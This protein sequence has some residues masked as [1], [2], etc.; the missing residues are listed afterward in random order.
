MLLAGLFGQAQQEAHAAFHLMRIH[1]VM[2][3][4]NAVNTIQYVELRMC[5]GGQN[6]VTGHTIRFYDDTNPTPVLK[7]TFT[8]PGDVSNPGFATGE[9]ILIATAEYNANHMGPGAG[10]SGGNADFIFSDGT[11]PNW[12]QNTVG[13]NGGDPLHPVQF[14]GG[15]VV[16]EE[17]SFS[18][19]CA[20]N[21]APLDSVAYGGAVPNYGTAAVALPSPSDN[22]ALRESNLSGPTNNSTDY[23]L[24]ATAAVPETVASGSLSTDLD[25]PRNNS[26]QVSQLTLDA[27]GDAVN[28]PTD[29][30][31]GTASGATVDSVG[32]SAAQVD[33]DA[34]GVCDVGAESDGPQN[35]TGFPTPGDLCPGTAPAAAV[36][37]VGC[38]DAQ[39]DPDNDGFCSPGAPDPPAGPSN[40][41]VIPAPDNCPTVSNPL[42]EDTDMDGIGDACETSDGDFDEV[43]DGPDNC[44]TAANA[45]QGNQDG[46]GLGDACDPDSDADGTAN[47]TDNDDDND[48]V[49]DTAEG[50]CRDDV[51]SADAN[52]F[53]ND[54]CPAVGLAESGAQCS[55]MM[56]ESDSDGDGFVNDG[57]PGATEVVGCGGD[58]LSPARRPERIDGAFLATDDDADGSMNEVLPAGSSGLDCDGDGWPGD[59]ENLLYGNAP[60]T[61]SNQ[62]PCGN[63]GWPT[64]L[65][66]NNAL[67]IAD[68][69]S[70]LN[71]PRSGLNPPV[72]AHSAFNKFSHPLDDWGAGGPGGGMSPDGTIDPEMARWNLQMPPHAATTAINIGDLNSLITGAAGSPARPP[73]FNGQQ[74]FFTD[75]GMCPWPA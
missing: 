13:A 40:C 75:G 50:E 69:G 71:P 33:A 66:A 10:G 53:V 3:G 37:S 73:M 43:L 20:G 67:N 48:G 59:Q 2:G 28:F 26:R 47:A 55:A 17:T 9:S 44:D 46:D 12:P 36:D 7:A 15:K 62:D 70:F 58:P 42:Q 6:F 31:A 8:F 64:D 74:A 24:Q 49:F 61:V 39:V 14:T 22:T 54:G 11:V 23:S 41:T 56:N 35:C 51:D 27:D 18:L 65:A 30:C 38:S 5:S 60:T 16:F 63:N 32:C 29:V 21:S 4:F 72:D 68:I 52:A 34:D 25:T 19:G 45:F 57:C 1:A